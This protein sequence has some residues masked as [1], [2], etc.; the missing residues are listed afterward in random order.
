[1][2]G[3]ATLSQ[4]YVQAFEGSDSQPDLCPNDPK[5]HWLDPFFPNHTPLN[6][7]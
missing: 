3:G 6:L 2:G 5:A 1:M 7:P 4:R